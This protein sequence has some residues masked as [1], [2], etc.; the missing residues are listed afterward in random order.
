VLLFDQGA[1]TVEDLPV[2]HGLL[3]GLGRCSVPAMM[4]LEPAL[5]HLLVS[6]PGR[7]TEDRGMRTRSFLL[8]ALVAALLGSIAAVPA[9]GGRPGDAEDV[10][11]QQL[12]R[13]RRRH[14]RRPALGRAGDRAERRH[15]AGRRA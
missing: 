6:G 1:D 11:R 4:P 3:R 15:R 13:A 8:A 14:H 2:V 5:L 10:G 7:M 12:R 9:R